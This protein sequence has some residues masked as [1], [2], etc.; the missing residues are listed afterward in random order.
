MTDHP[1]YTSA[2]IGALQAIAWQHAHAAPAPHVIAE[3]RGTG[4]GAPR[5]MST[6]EGVDL[7]RG[8]VPVVRVDVDG[9][10]HRLEVPA[11]A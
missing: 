11:P 6:A 5:Y 3:Y 9:I 10:P 2:L 8:W 4:R 1:A 7:G